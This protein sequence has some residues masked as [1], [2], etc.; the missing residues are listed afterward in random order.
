[1]MFTARQPRVTNHFGVVL[2]EAQTMRAK[3][4]EAGVMLSIGIDPLTARDITIDRAD[5]VRLI[6]WLTT[7]LKRTAGGEK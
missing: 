4:S 5:T 1:M 6:D 2:Q 7:E 3:V